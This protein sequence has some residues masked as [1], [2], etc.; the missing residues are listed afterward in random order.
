MPEEA[1][2]LQGAGLE[3]R[4]FGERNAARAP[5]EGLVGAERGSAI[6]AVLRYLDLQ[7]AVQQPGPE[8]IL[9]QIGRMR[10]HAMLT[11]AEAATV[12]PLADRFCRFMESD[13]G[14]RLQ[15]AE[16]AGRVYREMPFT[17]R[18]DASAIHRE[19]D[20]TGFGPE[21]ATLVQGII[22]LWFEEPEREGVVLVDFKSDRIRGTDAEI[23]RTLVDRYQTQLDYYEM[24]IVQ[25]TGKQVRARYIWLFDAEKAYEIERNGTFSAPSSQKELA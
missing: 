14:Q 22:D 7:E 16:T 9:R 11:P 6:H 12:E 13:L 10:E 24:A 8:G 19:R 18:F 23:A 25:S 3:I 4:T 1:R 21:D 2:W 5:N 17:L 20:A 15:W